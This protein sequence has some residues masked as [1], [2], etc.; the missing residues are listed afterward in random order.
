MKKTNPISISKILLLVANATILV[1]VLYFAFS[2]VYLGLLASGWAGNDVTLFDL[3]YQVK[4]L[5]TIGILALISIIGQV[6]SRKTGYISGL[7]FSIALFLSGNLLVLYELAATGT[8]SKNDLQLLLISYL[9]GAGMFLWTKKEFAI[10]HNILLKD[11]VFAFILAWISTIFL[12][13]DW[14]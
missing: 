2:I 10:E 14:F 11:W 5:L 13:M 4:G 12:L 6:I 8:V 9:A 3:I 7:G 1:V